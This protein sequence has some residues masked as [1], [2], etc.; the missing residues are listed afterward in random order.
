MSVKGVGKPSV[1]S[2]FA[3]TER[4]KQIWEL[5]KTK[6]T[7]EVAAALGISV[8]AVRAAY[9]KAREKLA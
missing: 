3:L 6:T 5:R 2:V 7:A 9:L 4:E 1:D 8:G